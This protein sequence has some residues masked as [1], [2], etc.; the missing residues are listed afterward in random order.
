M[1]KEKTN[2]NFDEFINLYEFSK[3]LQFSLVPLKLDKIN[4]KIIE[5]REFNENVVESI[6]SKAIQK[7]VQISENIKTTKFYLDILHREF[8]NDALGKLR[9]SVENLKKIEQILDKIKKVKRGKVVTDDQKAQK[10]NQIIELEKEFNRVKELLLSGIKNVLIGKNNEKNILITEKCLNIL[11]ER[12]TKEKVEEL[13]REN[14]HKEIIYP[15]IVYMDGKEEKSVFEM[16]AGYLDEFHK[17]REFLYSIGNKNGSLARR[18][19]DNFIK[20]FCKNRRIFEE[21]YKNSQIDFSPIEKAFDVKIDD[22]FAYEYYNNCISQVGI[23]E[24]NRLLGGESRKQEKKASIEGLNQIINLYRQKK[25]NEH[26]EKQKT[27]G[28]KKTKFNK[29]DYPFFE[30]LQKQILSQIFRKEILIESDDDFIR[31]L[32]FFIEK[33]KEKNQ[34]AQEIINFF[35]N[36][37]TNGLDLSKIYLPKKKIN[38]FAYKIFKEPQAFLSIFRNKTSSLE[39]VDFKKVEQFLDEGQFEYKDF[40]KALVNDRKGINAFF[41]VWKHEFDILID[42]GETVVKGGK[43]EK[44]ENISTKQIELEKWFKWFE[45]KVEKQEKMTDE[46]EGLWCFAVL[47][48]AQTILS[49]TKRA[50]IFWLNDKQTTKMS[51]SGKNQKFY[52][53]FANFVEDDFVPFFYF[54]KFRN[55]LNKRSRNT[56]KGI[57]FYFGNEHLLDGWDLSKENAYCGFLFRKDNNYYL[58]IGEKDALLFHD[59][60]GQEIDAAY[61]IDGSGFYEKIDY[62]QLDIGKFEGIAFPKKTE[63]KKSY[64]KA[65]R[66]RADEF[67]GGDIEKL[68]YFIDIRKEFKEFKEKRSKDKAWDRE[69]DVSKERELI[70]YYITCLQTRNE[71]RRF[72]LVFKNFENYQSVDDFKS[73]IQRQTYWINPKKVNEDYVNRKVGEGKLFLFRIHTKD[74][75]DFRK[76]VSNNNPYKEDGQSSKVN[77]FTQYFLELFSPENIENIKKKDKNGSIFEL[78]GKAEIRYRRA[79]DKV[80]QKTYKKDGKVVTYIDRWG[81]NRE[82]EVLQHRR[83]LK[84]TLTLHLKTRLNFGKQINFREFNEQINTELLNNVSVKILGMDRGENNLIYYCVLNE[85]G[86]IEKCGSLNKIGKRI[87]KLEDGTTRMEQVD[88]YKL[89]VERE[90]R[91]DWER[92][93]WQR[94][95]PIKNIKEGYLGNVKNWIVKEIFYNLD[96]GYATLNVLEDLNGG[97]KRSRFFRERQVYQN[98]EKELIEKLNYVVDKDRSNYR[99]A[100]QFTPIVPTVGEMEKSKQVGTLVYIPAGFTSKICPRCGWRKRLN[101]KNSETKEKIAGTKKTKGLLEEAMKIFYQKENDVFIFEYK[102][103]QECNRNGEKEKYNGIDKVFSSVS[104]TRWENSRKANVEFIDGTERS[105]TGLLKKLFKDNQIVIEKDINQQLIKRREELSLEFFRSIIF[106]FNLIVQI[107][108]YDREKQGGDADYIQCPAKKNGKPCMFDSRDTMSSDL[109][110]IVNGDA[111]GAYNIARKG[112]ILLTR[113]R[114]NPK[115]P[116][117]FLNNKDWDE[118]AS[119]WDKFVKEN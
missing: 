76:K 85:K 29:K 3:T 16:K 2:R 91:R 44:I 96:D 118:A 53:L 78:D 8:I 35:Y 119:D 56:A 5:E 48:Y 94:M 11:K 49:I 115:N 46:D 26:K 54:D 55:Y 104:R 28:K 106:Y 13:R 42:G 40:F 59:N 12:F 15:D 71:W 66:N 1:A 75:Y 70:K 6:L 92:K 111:N 116:N 98:F 82:K 117:L 107:R 114:K 95:T 113:I 14:K 4:N 10:K 103:E 21:K 62:K 63:S 31:E 77:L 73:N 69:F 81:G 17:N 33:S 43:E 112:F 9:F 87:K 74:F 58:G 72:N 41:Y 27:L 97:F 23:D 93:N 52:S 19:V 99:N 67:L 7:D 61:Q 84:N 38:S 65:L 25:E 68:K 80:K 102:W 101:I 90:E 18:I 20:I 105:I 89:L 47:D 34:K 24:Y 60:N 22:F 79:T 45:G 88:Y 50:E 36:Y 83:Y 51:E 109:K 100:Y 108:N 110:E 57:K 64:E 37:E 39:F 86:E 32:R 30:S